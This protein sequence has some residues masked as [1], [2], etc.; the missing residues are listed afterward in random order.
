MMYDDGCILMM[1]NDVWCLFF[2]C[3][4]YTLFSQP[5]LEGHPAIPLYSHGRFPVSQLNELIPATC[6]GDSCAW[7]DEPMEKPVVA[8]K[9][10]TRYLDFLVLYMCIMMYYGYIL[11]F[12]TNMGACT[13]SGF[14]GL[15]NSS[16]SPVPAGYHHGGSSLKSEKWIEMAVFD[17][18]M[19]R[20]EMDSSYGFWWL[21]L[22]FATS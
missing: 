8:L 13:S 11:N 16:W 20:I 18:P 7:P 10:Y 4:F 17:P 21:L 15:L 12:I 9:F 19:D 2:P 22:V 6:L 5:Y 1:M 14:Q 3:L